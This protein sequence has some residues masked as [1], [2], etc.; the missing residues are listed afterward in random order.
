[1]EA[2]FLSDFLLKAEICSVFVIKVNTE[3][4]VM[5]HYRTMKR[6]NYYFVQKT[7]TENTTRTYNW[8]VTP[9]QRFRFF[10][11]ISVERGDTRGA[12][13]K[14]FLTT[15]LSNVSTPSS[16]SK[17]QKF[18]LTSQL[19]KFLQPNSRKLKTVDRPAI[20]LLKSSTLVAKIKDP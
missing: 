15:T 13:Q 14:M 12:H 17:H 20:I 1:M 8:N 7:L 11:Q 16:T 19:A 18:V 10:T 6:T 4:V 3:F 5:L 9:T 2:T